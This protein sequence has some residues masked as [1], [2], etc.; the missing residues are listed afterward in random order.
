LVL[1]LNP[2]N[3]PNPVFVL[4]LGKLPV[5]GKPVPKL[6]FGLGNE[7]LLFKLK[8]KFVF[9]LKLV[10]VFIIVVVVGVLM[11]MLF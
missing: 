11:L 5:F 7:L 4:Q 3:P 2:P 10:F 9:G 1:E 6:K 8:P